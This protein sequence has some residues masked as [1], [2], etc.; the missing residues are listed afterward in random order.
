MPA[1]GEGVPQEVPPPSPASTEPAEPELQLEGFE[2]IHD[3][4][5]PAGE[6]GPAV[7][8]PAEP[9]NVEDPTTALPE[10][11]H[12]GPV[13]AAPEGLPRPGPE[14]LPLEPQR[15]AVLGQLRRRAVSRRGARVRQHRHG[16]QQG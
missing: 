3:P 7:G 9:E 4:I 13:L 10:L 5:A 6:P 15:A 16:H 2:V 14:P 8:V 11:L 12:G 1:Q